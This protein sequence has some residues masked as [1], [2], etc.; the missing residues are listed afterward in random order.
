MYYSSFIFT[1]AQFVEISLPLEHSFKSYS[2][3]TEFSPDTFQINL[4]LVSTSV[5]NYDYFICF[6]RQK[7]NSFSEEKD[8]SYVN[9][10]LKKLEFSRYLSNHKNVLF[11]RLLD[12]KNQFYGLEDFDHAMVENDV[13]YSFQSP[14]FVMEKSH[15][16]L[17]KLL[18]NQQVNSMIYND[19][20]LIR[21]YRGR[22]SDKHNASLLA[23][24]M[25][26]VTIRFSRY[27]RILFL[28]TR[29]KILS[30]NKQQKIF[31]FKVGLDQDVIM[32]VEK[33]AYVDSKRVYFRN[34]DFD[35]IEHISEPIYISRESLDQINIIELACDVESTSIESFDSIQ[36]HFYDL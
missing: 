24:A 33:P 21:L 26:K 30:A 36:L 7:F 22:V 28:E 3:V 12:L 9:F 8:Y 32:R 4:N 10:D 13:I 31:T 29:N 18:P 2:N 6:S 23:T 25:T 15:S 34:H 19:F 17:L 20:L 11:Y 16:F 1:Y 35:F 27:Q 5:F 14:E